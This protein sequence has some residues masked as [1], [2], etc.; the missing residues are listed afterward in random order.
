MRAAKKTVV[1]TT[2]AHPTCSNKS[3]QTSTTAITMLI[4]ADTSG[5]R[6]KSRIDNLTIIHVAL[7]MPAKCKENKEYNYW[8]E[9]IIITCTSYKLNTWKTEENELKDCQKEKNYTEA[10]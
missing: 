10:S 1:P 7:E 2:T 3:S 8:K 6:M 9:A 4:S 5:T